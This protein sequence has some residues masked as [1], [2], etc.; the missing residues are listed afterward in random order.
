MRDIYYVGRKEGI[1]LKAW[2]LA[3][4]ILVLPSS[5]EPFGAV[6]NE[7]LLAGEFAMVS[8]N[9]GATCLI[10]DENG[11]ILDIRKPIIDFKEITLRIKP[12]SE[13]WKPHKSRMPFLFQDK[14][15]LLDEWIRNV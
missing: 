7:A 5:Y 1:E 9:A 3:G 6:V 12:I 13:P 8:E 11:L 10:N 4:Q 15:I 2:Y 14:M